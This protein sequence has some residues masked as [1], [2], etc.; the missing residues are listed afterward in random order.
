MS[1]LKTVIYLFIISTSYSLPIRSYHKNSIDIRINNPNLKK[2]FL[3]NIDGICIKDI[4]DNLII[5]FDKY[6]INKMK[7]PNIILFDE[8][9]KLLIVIIMFYFITT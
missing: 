3:N 1:L 7:Y 4:N 9:I 5:S 8:I 2:T 6:T